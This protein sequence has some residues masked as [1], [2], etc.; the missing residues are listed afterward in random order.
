MGRG[1]LR[2]SSGRARH[3]RGADGGLRRSLRMAAR[4]RRRLSF[5][6]GASGRSCATM[7]L[8]TVPRHAQGGRISDGK[9]HAGWRLTASQCVRLSSFLL[10]AGWPVVARCAVRRPS[11]LTPARAAA[12]QLLRPGQARTRPCESVGVG[13]LGHRFVAVASNLLHCGRLEGR[14]TYVNLRVCSSSLSLASCSC[15]S[16]TW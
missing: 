10:I 2:R 1:W 12:S 15:V 8:A 5:L 11:F 6:R 16:H 14:C 13:L 7:S 9:R 4:L 3:A